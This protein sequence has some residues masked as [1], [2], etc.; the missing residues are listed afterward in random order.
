MLVECVRLAGKVEN[1][2]L[3]QGADTKRDSLFAAMECLRPTAILGT[4]GADDIHGSPSDE[5]G[6]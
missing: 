1:G 4:N 2:G 3:G 6:T 5:T